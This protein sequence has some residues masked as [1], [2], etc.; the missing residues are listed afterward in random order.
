MKEEKVNCFGISTLV[1]SLCN[2]AFYGTF[3]SYIMYKTKT[4]SF[5]TII[6]GFI[7]SLLLSKIILHLFNKHPSKSFVKRSKVN[8]FN[9]PLF[10]ILLMCTYILLSFRLST[11]LSNQYLINTPNFVILAMIALITYYT[12][13]KGIETIIRVSNITFYFSMFIFIFDFASLVTQIDIENFYPMF[14]TSLKDIIITSILFS[15]FFIT[16]N[17]Y[18]NSI[19]KSQIVDSDKFTKYYYGMQIVSLIIILLN[20]FTTIGVS[21]VNVNNL[22]DY[23]IYTTLKRISLFSFL[24]SMENVSIT[25]WM[26]FIYNSCNINLLFIN[27]ILKDLYKLNGLKLKIFNIIITFICFILPVIVFNDGFVESY[28]YII[29]PSVISSILILLIFISNIKDRLSNSN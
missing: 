7:I 24:D 19:K 20:M 16:P 15:I 10:I 8:K 11:F 4:D 17:I 14:T 22:F 18:L 5:L 9:G 3:S 6:I 2:S 1:L 12:S 25:L 21:G 29:L 27:N 23:P 26:F 28:E 13:S